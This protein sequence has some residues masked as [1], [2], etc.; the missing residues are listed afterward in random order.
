VQ[1]SASNVI[2]GFSA[3]GRLLA[4][5]STTTAIGSLLLGAVNTVAQQLGVVSREATTVGVVVRGAASQSANLTEWQ[6]SGGTAVARVDSSGNFIAQTVQLVGSG[7]LSS[8][9]ATSMGVSANRNV[10]LNAVGGSYGGGQAVTFIG[11]AS[12]VPSSNPTGGGILY[13]EAGALKFRGSSG[14]V[15]VIANA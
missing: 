10:F 15:T 14:S 12:T 1:D 6:N 4:G 2:G 13:V 11:N 3:T 8:T 7:I 5:G 9:G